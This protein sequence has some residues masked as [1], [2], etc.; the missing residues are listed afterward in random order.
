MNSAVRNC[1]TYRRAVASKPRFQRTALL[2][3]WRF[4]FLHVAKLIFVSVLIPVSHIEIDF[5]NFIYIPISITPVPIKSK[6]I[7]CAYHCFSR[8]IIK[9]KLSYEAV[10]ETGEQKLSIRISHHVPIGIRPS[11]TRFN[12]RASIGINEKITKNI[13][14]Y[15]EQLLSQ[16]EKWNWY[17]LMVDV[18]LWFMYR[19][20]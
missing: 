3:D 20:I 5:L 12:D 9:V 14:T 6:T 8:C 16:P 10:R 17:T 18:I 4:Y 15:D 2:E 19:N 11:A 7:N 13:V 1:I